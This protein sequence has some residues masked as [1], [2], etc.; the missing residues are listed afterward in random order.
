M[1]DT[2]GEFYLTDKGF[3]SLRYETRTTDGLSASIKKQTQI[4]DYPYLLSG[5]LYNY[6]KL[7]NSSD[8]NFG[9]S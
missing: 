1:D 4:S 7:Y 3:L 5:S 9:Y 6:Y 8:D 2:S